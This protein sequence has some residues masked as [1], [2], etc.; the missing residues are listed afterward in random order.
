[1][2]VEGV[3]AS[4]RCPARCAEQRVDFGAADYRSRANG[5]V[6]GVDGF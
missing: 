3:T 2:I 1:V 5:S 4:K 6:L